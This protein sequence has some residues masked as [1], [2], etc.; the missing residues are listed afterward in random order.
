VD[1]IGFVILDGN[2]IPGR[3]LY[4]SYTPTA[5][6]SADRFACSGHGE[7]IRNGMRTSTNSHRPFMF[8]IVPEES[9]TSVFCDFGG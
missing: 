4:G 3:F 7:A 8:Q 2:V 6:A 1:T 9:G 5:F